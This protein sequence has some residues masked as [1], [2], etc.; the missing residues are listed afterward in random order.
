M[1]LLCSHKGKKFFNLAILITLAHKLMCLMMGI[2]F[3]RLEVFLFFCHHP[4]IFH[5]SAVRR[6]FEKRPQ[7]L[8]NCAKMVMSL[9][10]VQTICCNHSYIICLLVNQIYVE[11]IGK[12]TNIFHYIKLYIFTILITLK[13]INEGGHFICTWYKKEMWQKSECRFL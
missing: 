8:P 1:S 10:C 13:E 3:N 9:Y 4:L 6:N 7:A 12:H 11:V 2:V 5:T